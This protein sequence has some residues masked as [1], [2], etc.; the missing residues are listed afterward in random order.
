MGEVNT[1]RSGIL[2]HIT[3]LPG[4]H[5]I[6]DLGPAAR[7]HADWMKKAGLDAWQVLPITP[8]GEGNSPYSGRSAFAMEPLLLSL[9][10]LHADGLLPRSALRCDASLR[11]GHTKYAAA[12]RFKTPRVHT[13]FEAFKAKRRLRS[14]PFR[15]FLDANAHWL[16]EWC[17]DQPGEPDEHAFV[18]FTLHRQWQ[19]LRAHA[20][21]RGVGFI[22]D[23]PLFVHADSTDVRRRPE[24]FRLDRSGNP[25]VVTGVP[26]DGY[27]RSGQLWGHPHYRWVAHRKERFAWWIDRFRLAIDRFDA[28][29]VDHF[30]GFIRLYEVSAGARTARH[31]TW[32]RTPGREL[33]ETLQRELG[34]LPLIAEDLGETTPAV[35]RLR[36]DFDLP[37][38]RIV[39]WAFVG[40]DSPDLPRNHPARSVCYP[41]THDNDTTRGWF[42]TLPSD[43]K[44]RFTAITG[45][46]RASDAA[47]SMIRLCM[48][49]PA[50]CCVI[51]MQ[52]VLNLGS[53]ARMNRPGT[54]RG[55]WTWRMDRHAPA[56]LARPM[57]TTS[58]RRSFMLPRP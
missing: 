10:D 7:A 2:L 4:G 17:D 21:T 26:P 46:R 16:S 32:R 3:S 8:I 42:R 52:D 11:S 24:L 13:A 37:G 5:G 39:Q 53:A 31:G 54:P 47:R 15:R 33:L 19:R 55:N 29:R 38:M 1:L 43:A 27:C 45:C 28:I 34:S 58:D 56:A 41:G 9:D 36:D 35:R 40:D 6:G 48:G 49:S 14:V 50:E 51:P 18:Q 22:G 20:A 44:A 12:R 25:T 23:V 30:I 57:R